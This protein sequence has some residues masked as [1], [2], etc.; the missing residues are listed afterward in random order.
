MNFQMN[1]IFCM[2]I[3]VGSDHQLSVKKSSM[4]RG[5]DLTKTND[6]LKFALCSIRY[7]HTF[8]ENE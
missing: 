1:V 4:S 7:P 5:G 6:R 8:L 3:F 2:F